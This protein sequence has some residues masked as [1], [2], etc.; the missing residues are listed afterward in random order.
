MLILVVVGAVCLVVGGVTSI[1][2]L[3]AYISAWKPAPM[4]DGPRSRL[5]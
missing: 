3:M 4:P 5:S 1:A 2:A